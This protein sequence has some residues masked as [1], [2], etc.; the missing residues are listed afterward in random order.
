MQMPISIILD[1][2]D[3]K[4]KSKFSNS[5]K[6]KRSIEK[7]VLTETV[8]RTFFH[9]DQSLNLIELTGTIDNLEV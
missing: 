5:K 6:E 2:G 1:L 3:E 7:V 9:L 8:P 4:K